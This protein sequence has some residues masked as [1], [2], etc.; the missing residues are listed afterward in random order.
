MKQK[1]C[2]K[3]KAQGSVGNSGSADCRGSGCRP[4]AK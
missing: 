2:G 1:N 4:D 3:E